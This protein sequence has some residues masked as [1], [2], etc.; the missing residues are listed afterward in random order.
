MVV[1]GYE[2]KKEE[3]GQTKKQTRDQLSP[4]FC[5]PREGKQRVEQPFSFPLIFPFFFISLSR[6]RRYASPAT[7]SE[8]RPIS[9]A[10]RDAPVRA[11]MPLRRAASG[12]G[13]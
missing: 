12:A 4:L 13:T 2:E 1:S 5:F 6:R 7:A 9:A 11:G 10:R 8:A 3:R